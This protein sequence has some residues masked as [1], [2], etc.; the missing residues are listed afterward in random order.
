MGRRQHR[1]EL[2][3]RGCEKTG[4]LLGQGLV[5]G[6]PRQ[7]ALPK[8]KIS[9]GQAIKFGS[10]VVR[11]RGHGPTI[12]HR[13]YNASVAGAKLACRTAASALRLPDMCKQ[14]FSIQ[15]AYPGGERSAA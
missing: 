1:G 12:A 4:D 8:I 10:R 15:L 2:R 13:G 14:A 6:Q 11:F 7:L 5:G 9:P 3:I